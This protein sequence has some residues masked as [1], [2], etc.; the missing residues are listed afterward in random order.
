MSS[1]TNLFIQARRQMKMLVFTV[2]YSFQNPVHIAEKKKNQ[3]I[4]TIINI[5]TKMQ[6]AR[7][8]Q[9]WKLW[10]LGENSHSKNQKPTKT[11]NKKD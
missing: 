5:I 4:S 11:K 9:A 1:S 3:Y 7:K 2:V 8:A 10:A 6:S